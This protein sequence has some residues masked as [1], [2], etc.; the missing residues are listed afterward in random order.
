[1]TGLFTEVKLRGVLVARVPWP[2][3][4]GRLDAGAIAMLPVGAA[5]KEH[6]YHLPMNTDFLQAEWFA[7]SMAEL[8]EVAVWPTLSYGY[9]PAFIDYPGSC[10][11]SRVTFIS[12][13]YEILEDIVRAGASSVVV[14]N[15][16]ISTIT[17]LK[18]AIARIASHGHVQLINCYQGPHYQ[19]VVKELQEQLRGG[20]ADEL[21]TSIM[22]AIAPEQVYMARAE[23]CTNSTIRGPFN[24]TDPKVANYSPSGV[25]GDPRLATRAKGER[26]V[27]A[28]LRD[29]LEVLEGLRGQA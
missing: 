5:C 19:A 28:I 2:E 4:Q 10:S 14:L 21:E 15:T 7:F 29:I 1:M 17:P 26:L 6:G 18:E 22:L 27:R 25:Y 16:G 23:A 8:A 9:Y 12:T 13:I 11:L 3:V 20:H 24:R